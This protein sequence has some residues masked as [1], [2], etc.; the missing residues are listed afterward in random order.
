MR[1]RD[2][3]DGSG[4]RCGPSLGGGPPGAAQHAHRPGSSR[5]PRVVGHLQPA[6]LG[7]KASSTPTCS[8][9]RAGT[10][11]AAARGEV[12]ERK[13]L[14]EM[15]VGYDRCNEADV[16]GRT[17]RRAPG[18]Q[19]HPASPLR[20]IEATPLGA[21]A[22]I[23]NSRGG[24]YYDDEY[25]KT[26]KGWRFKSRNVV[27]D[28][29]VA[30]KLTTQDFIEIRQLAGDDHGYYEKLYGQQN[31][32]ISPRD[33]QAADNRPFRISGLQLTVTPRTAYGPGLPAEQRRPLRGPLRQDTAGLADQGSKYVPPAA[34][35]A[36]LGSRCRGCRSGSYLRRQLTTEA[37]ENRSCPATSK[38]DGMRGRLGF[39][40]DRVDGH[41][42]ARLSASG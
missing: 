2:A 18:R 12:R 20:C 5:N 34:I 33:R 21:K 15:V 16:V 28:A 9:R 19:R 22:R 35:R 40:P 41:A 36:V 4:A 17:G 30:A 6:L 24:G 29:E 26:P 39:V 25:V 10:S 14:M 1:R 31:G 32:T 13:A 27:S 37:T 23:I 42:D 11:A 7:C 8:R 38:G 3:R